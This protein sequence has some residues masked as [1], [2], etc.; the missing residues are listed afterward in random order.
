LK[1][2]KNRNEAKDGAEKERKEDNK[3]RRENG[4][5]E[6]KEIKNENR[7]LNIEVHIK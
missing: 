6:L 4:N 3:K 1:G 5:K 7:L 2:R